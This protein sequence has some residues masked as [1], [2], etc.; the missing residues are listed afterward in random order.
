MAA[1][2]E[3]SKGYRER[4]QTLNEISSEMWDLKRQREPRRLW[5]EGKEFGGQRNKEREHKGKTRGSEEL[6]KFLNFKQ[7]CVIEWFNFKT[8]EA[9]IIL[10]E[11]HNKRLW[12][13]GWT[14]EVLRV[15]GAVVPPPFQATYNVSCPSK[16]WTALKTKTQALVMWIFTSPLLFLGSDPNQTPQ[17]P[18]ILTRKDMVT[19]K[20]DYEEQNS[21]FPQN[22]YEQK[23][24]MYL[25]W[26]A[27]CS[28][29]PYL[30]L[31]I[32]IWSV[33]V[34]LKGKSVWEA[35][36]VTRSHSSIFL[37]NAKMICRYPGVSGKSYSTWDKAINS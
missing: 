34:F 31:V 29:L 4:P 5:Q 32:L 21:L 30:S 15:L 24:S 33:F 20:H 16:K 2:G 9:T 10:K 11:T 13:C 8:R 25:L 1:E 3:V 18:N 19:F 28:A 14:V 17:V 7:Y 26:K 23:A 37:L 27:V 12:E 22:K 36:L 6:F 35:G